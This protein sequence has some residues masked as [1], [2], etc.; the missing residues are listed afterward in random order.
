MKELKPLDIKID[1]KSA[2]PVYEQIKQGI[3]SLVLSGYLEEGDRMMPIRDLA[4]LLQVNSNTIVKVY[5]Q[6]DIEGYLES[7]HGSGYFI[8]FDSQKN[9]GAR[10]RLFETL[11]ADYISKATQLGYSAAEIAGEIK[12]RLKQDSK[13]ENK[14]KRS[15]K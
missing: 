5:Y 6:L 7:Q 12:K 15:K 10:E 11:T 8:K 14:K 13:D 3:K 1:A 4:E 9:L 2:L